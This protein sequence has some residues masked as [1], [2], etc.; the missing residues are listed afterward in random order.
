MLASLLLYALTSAILLGVGGWLVIQGQLTIGQLV[1][2]ELILSV[3][4]CRFQPLLVITLSCITTCTLPWSNLSQLQTL[5]YETIKSTDTRVDWHPNLIF[6]NVACELRSGD[7]FLDFSIEV[8]EKVFIE[9][10]SSAQIENFTS[11][12]LNFEKPSAGRITLGGFDLDDFSAHQLRDDVIVIDSTLLPE[13]S[14]AEY[15]AIAAPDASRARM[16][17]MLEVVGLQREVPLLEEDIERRL[18]PYGSPLSVAGVIKLKIAFAL[19]AQPKIF[20]LTPLFDMLS[21]EARANI[22]DFLRT[23]SM[24]TVICFSHRYDLTHFDSF[25]FWDF[26]R[27]YDYASIQ[28]LESAHAL[29]RESDPP[30]AES[31]TDAKN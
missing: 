13:C 9:T 15:L 5:P 30:D 29:N 22:M 18:T 14:V 11:L 1:A 7:Y 28:A 10:R 26:D 24:P 21:R 19:L 23:D 2:A 8:G 16:R 3:I 20:V 12:L 6:S 27:Q 31:T 25:R 4:F 17:S